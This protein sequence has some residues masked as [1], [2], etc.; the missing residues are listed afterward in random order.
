VAAVFPSAEG[1]YEIDVES[2][3][4]AAV[5]GRLMI[6]Q[7]TT[8]AIGARFE[9]IGELITGPFGILAIVLIVLA[10]LLPS[11]QRAVRNNR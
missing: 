3:A 10:L 8:G 2:D 6:G 11:F 7:G 5:G 4:A 9:K 1:I